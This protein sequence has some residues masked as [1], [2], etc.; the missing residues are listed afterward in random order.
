[1][2]SDFF[3]KQVFY[4]AKYKLLVVNNTPQILM[5]SYLR[6]FFIKSVLHK[7]VIVLE[8]FLVVL[9]EIDSDQ[10]LTRVL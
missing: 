5:K 7:K 3:K 6:K 10:S 1:M 8:S 4:F 9:L 2:P